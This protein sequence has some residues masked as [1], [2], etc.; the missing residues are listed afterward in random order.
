MSLSKKSII[1]ELKDTKGEEFDYHGDV[2]S[3]NATKKRPNH[4]E[5]G[6]LVV[7]KSERRKG[8]GKT[9]FES[10]L[11][12]LRDNNITTVTVDVQAM[13]DGSENDRLMK[14]LRK[15]NFEHK[16]SYEHYNWGL[17]IKAV[18]HI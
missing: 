11:S 18:A 6:H 17:C 4:Y 5:V 14:F 2:C 3:I 1:K 8:Y 9:I 15:Y 13:D 7:A 16:G 12:V 10:L